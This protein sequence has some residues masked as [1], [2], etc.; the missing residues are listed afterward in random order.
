MSHSGF[1]RRRPAENISSP[2][3]ALG[4]KV[5]TQSVDLVIRLAEEGETAFSGG[6]TSRD[7]GLSSK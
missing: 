7:Q 2:S 6:V 1:M 5:I 4:L 3:F